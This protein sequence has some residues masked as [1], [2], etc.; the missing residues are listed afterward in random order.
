VPSPDGGAELSPPNDTA[1]ARVNRQRRE[2][3]GLS[4]DDLAARADVSVQALTAYEQA[5]GA[6]AADLLVEAR[7]AKALDDA[8][9]ELDSGTTRGSGD[10]R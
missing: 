6:G 7:V 1:S 9:A 4:V 10:D 5:G 8:E 2:Q 3:L